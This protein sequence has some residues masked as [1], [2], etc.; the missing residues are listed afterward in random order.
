MGAV[1]EAAVSDALMVDAAEAAGAGIS[2]D[3]AVCVG[4]DAAAADADDAAAGALD[5]P[6]Q[7]ANS[8]TLLR[9]NSHFILDISITYPVVMR[10]V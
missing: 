5:S 2:A 10:A 7:A 8:S 9:G 6:P 3:A 4:V 1:S